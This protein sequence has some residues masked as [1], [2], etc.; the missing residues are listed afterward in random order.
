MGVV[1][2]LM[3]FFQIFVAESIEGKDSCGTGKSGEFTTIV[4]VL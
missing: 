2:K 4:R 3:N 1:H